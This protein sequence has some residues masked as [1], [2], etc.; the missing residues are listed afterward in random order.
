MARID[1]RT[2]VYNTTASPEHLF[3]TFATSY[4]YEDISRNPATGR[5]EVIHR[6]ATNKMSALESIINIFRNSRPWFDR[7]ANRAELHPVIRKLLRSGNADYLTDWREMVLEY[8]HVADLDNT[9]VAFTESDAKGQAD[10]QTVTTLGKYIKRHAP[11][12]PDH[13]LRDIVALSITSV[14]LVYDLAGMIEAV[15]TGPKSCM[16]SERWSTA[17][18]PYNVYDPQYGWHMAVR[19]Q[20][21]AVVGRCLCLTHEGQSLFVRS[22]KQHPENDGYSQSDEGMNAWLSERGYEHASGWPDGVKLRRIDAGDGS[23]VAPYIDGCSQT[24]SDYD[25][26]LMMDEN[27]D[28]ECSSTGGYAES[29]NR[30]Y[31]ADCE[32]F[33]DSESGTWVGYHE[34][35][36]VCDNCASDYTYVTGRRGSEYYI[37]DNA[38]VWVNEQ[39]YDE[40]YLE[41]NGIVYCEDD[42]EYRLKDD[43]VELDCEG[44]WIA[45][46]V[47]DEGDTY[48]CLDDDNR[49]WGRRD[50]CWY[51]E[52]DEQWYSCDQHSEYYEDQE[53]ILHDHH[54]VEF[55]AAINY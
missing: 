5:R 33:F 18:H 35:H 14:E 55:R 47:A 10:R 25:T 51:C 45:K 11:T 19:R 16:Q 1:H 12:I 30:T 43:C 41:S 42:S 37:H 32:D 29:V 46:D 24:C 15:Q 4:R 2:A 34:D 23:V 26:H 50:D 36:H 8:P 7:E 38:V 48:V 27:G 13:V 6:Y 9:K 52:K 53:P 21:G 31:C 28:I 49:I 39:P 40:N 54:V 17:N 20:A 44:T 3:C 22:Y